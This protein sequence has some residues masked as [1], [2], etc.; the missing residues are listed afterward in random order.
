VSVATVTD[1]LATLEKTITGVR[2]AYSLDE[3]PNTLHTLP[4]FVNWPGAATYEVHTGIAVETRTYRCILYVTPVQSP[5][6]MRY[7]GKLAEPLLAAARSAFLGAPGLAGTTGVLAMQ[8]TGDSG[9]VPI[10]D[11]GGVYIGAEF[12]V[13]VQEE[14]NVT[15]TD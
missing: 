4:A 9:L 1:A 10:D 3:T 7:K 5:V 8:F 6:E 11:Y 2:A 13:Q 14:I 12:T 15:Y